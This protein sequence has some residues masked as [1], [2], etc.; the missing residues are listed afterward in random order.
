MKISLNW[1]N[2][3]IDIEKESPSTIANLLTISG[4]EVEGIEECHPQFD[5]YN[6]VIGE[7]KNFFIH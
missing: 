7:I 2:D 5:K 6:L 4:V 1:L 3:F